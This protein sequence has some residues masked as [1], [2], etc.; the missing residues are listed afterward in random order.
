MADLSRQELFESAPIPKSVKALVVPTIISQLIS[1]VYNLTDTFFVGM[2]NSPA[3]SA[4]IAMSFPVFLAITALANLFGIG[5][6]SLISRSLGKSDLETARKTSVFAIYTA[7]AASILYSLLILVFKAPILTFLGARESTTGYLGSYL[8]WVVI[9]GG[10]PSIMN[11]VLA[12]IV[13]SEGAAKQASIGMSLGG[14]LNIMLDPIFILPFG[15]NLQVTGA[16]IATM[17][18]NT[19][20]TLYFVF[21][22]LRVRKTSVI[23]LSPIY[24]SLRGDI[25]K[26]VCTVGLPAALQTFMSVISNSVLNNLVGK[27]GDAAL[28]AVGIVKKIDMLPMNISMGFAQGSLPLMGYNFAAKKFD[29]MHAANVYARTLAIGFSVFCVIVFEVFA[30]PIVGIFINDPETIEYGV[31]F[32]RILCVATPLMAGCVMI[33]SVFQATGEGGKAM[34]LSF[35]RKGVVDVPLMFLLNSIFPIYGLIMVQPIV[36]AAAMTISFFMYSRFIKTLRSKDTE[37]EVLKEP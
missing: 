17:I 34:F 3:Q 20:A 19:V 36:D 16:A 28:A 9:I 32:L 4:A 31:R 23:S 13:R 22:L 26:G 37:A 6:S 5:G 7:A 24:Y 27:A 11:V 30:R 8:D 35:F 21:Y 18:S 10:L 29:R 2:L 14:T 25:V 12:H 15:F 1:M 33:I